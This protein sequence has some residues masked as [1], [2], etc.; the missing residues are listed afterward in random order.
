MQIAKNSQSSRGTWKS[1]YSLTD[2]NAKRWSDSTDIRIILLKQNKTFRN[3]LTASADRGVH[4]VFS[5]LCEEVEED[6]GELV[7][8][9]THTTSMSSS[10]DANKFLACANNRLIIKSFHSFGMQN[11]A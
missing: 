4:D 2:L 7:F 10:D 5:E 3:V 11:I 6:E 1:I 8:E 9:D